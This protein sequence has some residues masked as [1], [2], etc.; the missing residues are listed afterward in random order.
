MMEMMP[1]RLTAIS[2]SIFHLTDINTSILNSQGAI[3]VRHEH[4]LVPDFLGE[5]FQQDLLYLSTEAEK[6]PD[7]CCK[8]TN[9]WGLS[10]L[11][12]EFHVP[13]DQI[14]RMVIGPF[15]M[16]VP[17]V[18]RLHARFQMDQPKRIE[19]EGFYRGLKMISAAKVQSLANILANIDTFSQAE[20]R[21]LAASQLPPESPRKRKL[22]LQLD[23]DYIDLID[24]RYRTEQEMMRAVQQGDQEL[25]QQVR[26]NMKN[27]YDF[28]ERFPNQPI[29]ALRNA[30]IILNTLLRVAARNANVQPFFLHQISEKYAKLNE[31]SETIDSL[32]K[33]MSTMFNDYCSLVRSHAVHG[34]SPL[35]QNAVQYITLHY[36]KPLNLNELAKACHAHP[37]HLSRQFRKET[38]TTLTDFQQKHRVKEAKYLLK[39]SEMPVNTVAEHVGYDDAGYFTRI[40]KKLEGMTPSEFQKI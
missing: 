13:G 2:L 37:V 26:S 19:L 35:I 15:L 22:L 40:F 8:L 5:L 12:K 18:N 17:D 11:A 20:I 7:I 4:D 25:L 27:L 38:G 33:L 36:N 21:E 30:L 16:Q 39:N 6:S 32:N 1:L 14:K 34:V 23:E 9:E 31:R 3:Q 24:L 10:Y 28:S 29:R